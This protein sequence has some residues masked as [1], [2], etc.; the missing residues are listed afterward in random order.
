VDNEYRFYVGI[1]WAS[2]AHQACVL[3]AARR[4][5]SERSFA[6][7]GDALAAFAEWLKELAGDDP[8]GVAV[9]IEIPRGA[10]VETLVERGFH[11]YAINPKQLD[12]FRDR[13]SV[14]GA[15][16]DRRDAF[17]LGDSLRTDRDCFRRVRLDDPVVIQLR[18][19]SRVD[20]DLG[21]ENNQLA[22]RL[23]EQLHRFYVQA[24]K[25]CPGADEPWLWSLLELAPSPAAARGLRSK[26]GERLLREHRIRRLSAEQV[27]A[28]LRAPALQVAPGVAEAATEHIGLLLPR[29]RLVHTQRQR[30]GERLE[31]LLDQLQATPDQGPKQR[32]HRDVEILRSLP[33]VGRVVAATVLAEASWALAER[34]Y[35]ALRA[36]AGIAPITKQ[37]GK[38]RVVLMRYAC[39]VRLRNAL[40]H[41]ARVAA[42]CDPASKTYY[43]ALR[44]RGH[45]YP[46]ALRALGDRLLRVLIAMRK[47]DSLYDASKRRSR[48]TPSSLEQVA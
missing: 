22:N 41:W 15:K 48:P 10:V 39:N 2:E 47:N 9:A 24:L 21:R 7:A 44:G 17:V 16:D 8:G 29:L 19:L 3:D 33:G 11:V 35:H 42:T 27:L 18:E 46:R 38:H 34:D 32:E 43:A 13:H 45:S 20:E 31:A 1:D 36:H 12:R 25:L 5:I 14:A 40:F 37:S 23:R 4:I 28:A 6:H 26:R 30:C